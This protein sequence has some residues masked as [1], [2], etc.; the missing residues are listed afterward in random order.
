M[1]SIV[2]VAESSGLLDVLSLLVVSR[3]RSVRVALVGVSL[4]FGFLAA[5]A[6][7]DTIAIMGP[8]MVLFLSRVLNLDPKPLLI[9]LAFSITIG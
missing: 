9:L 5:V 6:V 1:F 4:V 8:P 2:G 3:F 7:N